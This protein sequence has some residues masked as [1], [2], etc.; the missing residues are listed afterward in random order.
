[1]SALK[2]LEIGGA[3]ICY[4]VLGE[5]GPSVGLVPYGWSEPMDAVLPTA[6]R[7]ATHSRVLV[8]DRRCTGGSDYRIDQHVIWAAARDLRALLSHE[9]MLPAY[10]GGAS[11]GC[12]STIR[13]ALEFPDDVRG[14]LLCGPPGTSTELFDDY[15]GKWDAAADAVRRHGIEESFRLQRNLFSPEYAARSDNRA[16]IMETGAMAYVEAVERLAQR[17]VAD[18]SFLDLATFE[19]CQKVEVPGM[20]VGMEDGG[21]SHPMASARKLHELLPRSRLVAEATLHSA[22]EYAR[23]SK[24]TAPHRHAALAPTWL[25]FID[26]IENDTFTGD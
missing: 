11:G 25:E 24:W 22:D 18:S 7:L 13:F 17:P 23:I 3:N 21:F 15:F 9:R 8:F 1:M 4:R 2:Y 10:V 6:E 12:M 19:E 14:M 26:S 16:R 20:V 5:N